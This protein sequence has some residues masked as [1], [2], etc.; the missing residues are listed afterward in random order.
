MKA[1]AVVEAF[2]IREQVA[3]GLVPGGVGPV[4]HQ[5]GF[6]RWKKLSPGALSSGL[7]RRLIDGVMSARAS[8]AW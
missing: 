7:A 5:L 1:L 3:L 4:V 2:P 8:A 6:Q